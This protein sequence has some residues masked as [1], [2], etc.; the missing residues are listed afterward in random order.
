MV[1]YEAQRRRRGGD[2][3]HYTA[4]RLSL[5]ETTVVALTFV[6]FFTA[7]HLYPSLDTMK[8]HIFVFGIV[9]GTMWTA[10]GM[11]EYDER[12]Q[13]ECQC[14]YRHHLGGIATYSK[15]FVPN[16]HG[17]V[18]Y[19][20]P[21]SWI[22][23]MSISFPFA[24]IGSLL[25]NVTVG[26][27]YDAHGQVDDDGETVCAGGDCYRDAS[28]LLAIVSAVFVFLPLLLKLNKHK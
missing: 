6:E 5:I 28:L 8:T 14:I 12:Q 2:D 11:Y 18:T 19:L 9:Y 3:A 16:G 22:T 10:N 27:M 26:L 7:M 17:G 1:Y 4:P 20:S 24:S 23:F 25:F 21:N 13:C 15:M